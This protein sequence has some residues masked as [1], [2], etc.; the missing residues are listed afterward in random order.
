LFRK[1]ARQPD[2]EDLIEIERHWSIQDSCKFYK[3]MNDVRR[4]FKPKVAM[5]RTKN[6]ELFTNKN[7]VLVK[8]KEHF[9]EHLNEGS[10]TEQPTRKIDLRDDGVD[11]NLPSRE[12]KDEQT[13]KKPAQFTTK[14]HNYSYMLII[15]IST[16]GVSKPFGMLSIGKR[17]SQSRVKNK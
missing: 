12:D 15:K 10:D 4:P 17:S 6:D 13:H 7:Q 9:E 1:K 14:K 8:W 11:I 3:R 5:C 16:I 2:E